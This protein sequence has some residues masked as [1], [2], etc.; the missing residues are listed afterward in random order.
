MGWKRIEIR[1]TVC[2]TETALIGED[3]DRA[4]TIEHFEAS[5]W[6]FTKYKTMCPK[7]KEEESKKFQQVVMD[8]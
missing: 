1:C 3:I 7:C 6:S 4:Y 5:G 8:I 2:G